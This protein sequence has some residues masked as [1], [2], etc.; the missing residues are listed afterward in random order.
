MVWIDN[1]TVIDFATFLLTIVASCGF[2]LYQKIRHPEKPSLIEYMVASR[3]LTLPLFVATLVSTWYG[4]ILAVTEISYKHGLYNLITQGVFWYLSA[5]IF[6]VFIVSKACSQ[7]VLTLPE[8]IEKNY[9]KKSSYAFAILL[10]IKALPITYAI[11]IGLVFKCVFGFSLEEGI[12]IGTSLVT[13]YC[14]TGGMKGLIIIN[15]LQFILM[16]IAIFSVVICSIY[17][18]GWL[19]YLLLKLP[20]S[21]FQIQGNH[22]FSTLMLWLIIAFNTTILSPVFYQ[23]CF[24]AQSPQIAKKGIFVS[25]LFWL[26]CDICTTFGGMYAKAFIPYAEPGTAYLTYGLMVLPAGLKGLFLA[27]IF[28]TVFS[29]LGSYIFISSN[30]LS[31]DLAVK[32]LRNNSLFRKLAVMLTGLLTIVAAFLFEGELEKAW[33][34][35]ESF[36]M[37]GTLLPLILAYFAKI[38][39][40]GK[41]IIYGLMITIITLFTWEVTGLSAYLESFFIGFLVNCLFFIYVYFKIFLTKKSLV[42]KHA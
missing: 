18:F 41:D 27:A 36:F 10:L 25:M 9:G 5:F 23:K 37:A 30:I 4:S 34:L 1:L 32:H 40:A 38:K 39:P 31:Y 21:H 26:I 17:S 6:A 16:F 19:D 24:A 35:T 14:M 42:K 15:I 28:I 13:L 3:A 33:I 8:I 29:A 7:K 2:I 12:I 20:D 11:S 22:N